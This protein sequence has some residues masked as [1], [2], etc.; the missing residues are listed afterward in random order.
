MQMVHL[1][2]GGQHII[3]VADTIPTLGHLKLPYVMGYD[4]FPMTTVR[5]KH[6]VLENATRHDW[7]LAFVHDPDKGFARVEKT[8]PE[9]YQV[10]AAAP[11]LAGLDQAGH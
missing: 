6:E 5:E 8:G 7:V 4:L 3:Y 11:D 1:V 9:R 10:V 2:T